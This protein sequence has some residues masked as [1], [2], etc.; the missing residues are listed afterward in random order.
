[1]FFEIRYSAENLAEKL[2]E[3]AGLFREEFSF[4][5]IIKGELHLKQEQERSLAWE[6]TVG[7]KRFCLVMASCDSYD[8]FAQVLAGCFVKMFPLLNPITIFWMELRG[9]HLYPLNALEDFFELVTSISE[10]SLLEFSDLGVRLSLRVDNLKVNI[11]YQH[12]KRAQLQKYFTL[13]DDLT[14]SKAYLSI[15][16]D[17]SLDE[18]TQQTL[19]EQSIRTFINRAS[20]IM[21]QKIE[22][23]KSLEF[24]TD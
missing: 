15:D 16:I 1:M 12:L 5:E 18:P 17:I 11:I 14:N 20:L 22:K 7:P 3:I 10:Y 2:N 23:I 6:I 24:E 13:V 4:S 19:S 21:D 8:Q 9:H